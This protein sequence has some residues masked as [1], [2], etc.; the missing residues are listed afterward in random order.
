MRAILIKKKLKTRLADTLIAQSCIDH[1][2]P[3]I[4][5]DGDCKHFGK[6]GGLELF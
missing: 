4:T 3:L 1:Q 2:I 6:Y 5:C